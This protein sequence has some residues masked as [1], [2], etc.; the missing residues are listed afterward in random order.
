MS[1]FKEVYQQN[2]RQLGVEPHY[3]I[4]TQSIG[5][6]FMSGIEVGVLKPKTS[7]K[8]TSNGKKKIPGHVAAHN[9]IQAT[10]EQGRSEELA[11]MLGSD[12]GAQEIF[13][14][15]KRK[16]ENYGSVFEENYCPDLEDLV[17]NLSDRDEK[18][19][20]KQQYFHDKIDEVYRA[21]G[22]VE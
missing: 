16:C 7:N 13:N 22:L 15:L 12:E 19:E 18:K 21:L 4:I 3:E 10:K 17:K 8:T 6:C 9:F 14:K 1:T 11:R 2:C 5:Q 20:I